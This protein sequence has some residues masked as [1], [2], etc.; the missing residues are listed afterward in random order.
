MAQRFPCIGC[1]AIVILLA[2]AVPPL[3]MSGATQWSANCPGEGKRDFDF[4]LGSW[5][6][7]ANGQPAGTNE[8]RAL[9]GGC[10]LEEK[11]TSVR[12][13]GGTSLN[14]FD[15]AVGRWRQVWVSDGTII[16]IAGGLEDRSMVLVGTIT[17]T[18]DARRLPFRGR[19]TPLA[20][21][22]VRQFFEE[23]REGAWQPWFEG[24]YT[25][26]VK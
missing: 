6:V 25:K 19:W 4:W 21:G 8:I 26:A 11:W 24:I 1:K 10:L 7:T 22:R 15:P 13:G 14:F 5:E 20:D 2:L 18:A 9:H 3:A 12:G 23:Q 16:D 17:Y